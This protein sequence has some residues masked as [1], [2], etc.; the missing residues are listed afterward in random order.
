MFNLRRYDLRPKAFLSLRG[1]IKAVLS[2]AFE[3]YYIFENPYDRVN[4]KKFDSMLV[5]ST[6]I[7]ERVHSKDDIDRILNYIHGYQVIA[8]VQNATSLT[9]KSP[10]N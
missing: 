9:D 10:K 6:P 5:K 2:Y 1:I 4:F 7:S 3:E 8:P